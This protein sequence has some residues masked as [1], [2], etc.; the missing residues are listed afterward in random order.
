MISDDEHH[1]STQR[2]P[3]SPVHLEDPP[4]GLLEEFVVPPVNQIE[5]FHPISWILAPYCLLYTSDAADD[6]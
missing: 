3:P 5:A 6:M 1:R 4:F 2:S